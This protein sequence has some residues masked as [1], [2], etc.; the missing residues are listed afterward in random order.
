MGPPVTWSQYIRYWP[1]YLRSCAGGTLL[2]LPGALIGVPVAASIALVLNEVVLPN[3]A[4][5]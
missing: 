4:Q 2:G 5:R 3:R 1:T